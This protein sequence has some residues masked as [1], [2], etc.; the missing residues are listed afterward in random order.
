M[1]CPLPN[2]VFLLWLEAAELRMW[3]K[4]CTLI[5]VFP[6]RQ[7]KIW[8]LRCRREEFALPVGGGFRKVGWIPRLGGALQNDLGWSIGVVPLTVA[9]Y[10]QVKK[11]VHLFDWL[12]VDETKILARVCCSAPLPHDPGWLR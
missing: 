5:L 9:V 10:A 12:T 11:T 1:F 4:K 3:T 6:A 2:Q 8:T 7:A